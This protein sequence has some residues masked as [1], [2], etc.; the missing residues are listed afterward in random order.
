MKLLKAAMAERDRPFAKVS[1]SI[2]GQGNVSL[3]SLTMCLMLFCFI[4]LLVF[5]GLDCLAQHNVYI[6]GNGNDV[7]GLISM[8]SHFF[9][10]S[11][12]L[13]QQVVHLN[14]SSPS[15]RHGRGYGLAPSVIQY[16]S[17][18]KCWQGA[19]DACPLYVLR[20]SG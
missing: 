8:P 3:H 16:N 18:C 13:K 17:V 15:K 20:F 4:K 10:L 9:L 6:G 14:A 5:L 2:P 12:Q 7:G 19:N 1:G 11:G